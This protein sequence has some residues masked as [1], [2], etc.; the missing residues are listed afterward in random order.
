VRTLPCREIAVLELILPV[1]RL[2]HPPIVHASPSAPRLRS[3]KVFR[4]N[5]RPSRFN[6]VQLMSARAPVQI[7]TA[8]SMKREC[9]GGAGDTAQYLAV[10]T[11]RVQELQRER[12]SVNDPCEFAGRHRLDQPCE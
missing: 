10:L 5:I 4:F 9:R 8:P 2:I 1:V 12:D 3:D 11:R 6:H 7:S